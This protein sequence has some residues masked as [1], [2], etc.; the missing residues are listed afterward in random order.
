[1]T[2]PVCAT[3]EL[4]HHTAADL[5]PYAERNPGGLTEAGHPK[6]LVHF[7]AAAM[8]V[9]WSPR[10][11]SIVVTKRAPSE[12]LGLEK[13]QWRKSLRPGTRQPVERADK[14]L[15]E[16]PVQDGPSAPF[17]GLI[18]GKHELIALLRRSS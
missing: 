18:V 2:R 11:L 1:M 7:S 3:T 9:H 5:S 13:V 17:G 6:Y 14:R 12:R 16:I 10:M 15:S 8:P 4:G